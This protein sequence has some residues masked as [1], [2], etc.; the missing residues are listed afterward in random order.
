[1]KENQPAL[2]QDIKDYFD[3]IDEQPGVVA[4]D[5]WTGELEKDHGRIERRSVTVVADVDWLEGNGKWKD[6]KRII[7][8]RRT[9]GAQTTITDR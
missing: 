9:I 4:V 8:Y 7:R 3:Y 6:V 5:C 2:Y 1:V